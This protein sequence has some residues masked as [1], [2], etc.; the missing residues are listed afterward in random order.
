M[1]TTPTPAP[2]PTGGERQD[3]RPGPRPAPPELAALTDVLAG[4]QA[5][6][7]AY[8]VVGGQAGPER[9]KAAMAGLSAHALQRDLLAARL[10]TAGAP[11]L[12]AP[13][14]YSLPFEVSSVADARRLA[15]HVELTLAGGYADL[16]AAAVPARRDEAAGWLTRCALQAR[17]WGATP[18]PFPGLPERVSP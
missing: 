16:V 13:P 17:G 2:S 8:G 11:P 5:A 12:A 14:A 7:Y 10:S 4:E 18:Q 3:A 15:V 6:V 9:R 1:T